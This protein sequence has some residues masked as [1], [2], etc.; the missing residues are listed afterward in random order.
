METDAL[1]FFGDHKDVFCIVSGFYLD[2]FVAFSQNN[3]LKTVFPYIGVL[4]HGSLFGHTVFGSHKQIMVV[5]IFFHGD[6]SRDLL[7]RHHLKKIDNG[8]APGRAACLRDSVGFQAVYPAGVGK[9]HD[10]IVI[11]GHDQ[12]FDV[13]LLDG[14]HAFDSLASPVL[15]LEIVRRHPLNV[16][17]TGHG[18]YRVVI[19]DQIFHRHV[20]LI[21]S[22]GSP[23]VIPVLVGDQTD[24]FSDNSQ[25]FFLVCQDCLQLRYL[26][27]K[28]PVF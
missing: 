10:I 19:G 12:I 3:S 27:L 20:K 16:S 22:D 13:V 1:S 2:Q 25:K 17:Q 15:A 26:G 8:C 28:F 6:D 7:P 5:I 11:L 9:E 4:S 21:K 24:L 18:H 14:L 23:P